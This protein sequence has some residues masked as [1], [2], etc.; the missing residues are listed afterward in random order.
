MGAIVVVEFARILYCCIYAQILTACAWGDGNFADLFDGAADFS[1][2]R[3]AVTI[4][5]ASNWTN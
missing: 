5:R 3:V 4:S 2:A 1:S